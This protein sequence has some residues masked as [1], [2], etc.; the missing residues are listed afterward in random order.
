MISAMTMSRSTAR[1]PVFRAPASLRLVS[2]ALVIVWFSAVVVVVLDA[3]S[4]SAVVSVALASVLFA[5]AVTPALRV[6]VAARHDHLLVNN[7]YRNRRLP[8]AKVCGF[9]IGSSFWTGCVVVDLRSGEELALSA[10]RVSFL[11]RGRWDELEAM[12]Q[13][14]AAHWSDRMGAGGR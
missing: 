14:L 10:T 5:V 1:G 12:R 9:R 4:V 13:M 6:V 11:G 7:G 2:T 3:R 8:W